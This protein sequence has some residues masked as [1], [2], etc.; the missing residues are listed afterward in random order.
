[1]ATAVLQPPAAAAQSAGQQVRLWPDKPS[2]RLI[3]SAPK[4]KL[5][6]VLRLIGILDTDKPEDVALRVIPLKNVNAADLA[7]ELGP[8][9]QK[10]GGKSPR[11]TIEVA[12]NDRSN[13]LIVLS[14]ETNF[15]AIEKLVAGLDTDEAMEKVTRTFLLKNA[16]AQDVAKQLQDLNKDQDNSSRYPYFFFSSSELL[17]QGLEENERGGRPPPQLRHRPGPAR[18]NGRARE[19]DPGTGR[20]RQRRQPGAYEFSRSSTSARWISKTCSMSCS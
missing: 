19:D 16:D 12:A 13:S 3:I 18:A 20:A 14:S 15:K 5:P 11:D 10:T 8:L 1:M 9:Y 17:L 7:K 2:N 4:S 6:E